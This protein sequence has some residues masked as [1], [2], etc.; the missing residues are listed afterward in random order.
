MRVRLLLTAGALALAGCTSLDTH[1]D[2]STL[3]DGLRARAGADLP[4]PSPSLSSE[5]GD[6]TLALLRAPIDDDAAVK[7][8]LLENHRVRAV[9]ERLGIARSDLVQAGLLRNPVFDADARFLFDGGTE[10]ELGLAQPFVDLFWLPLRT[11]LAEH[12]F[13]AAQALLTDELVHVVFAVRRAMAHARAAN[14]VADVARTGLEAATASH[15]L[16]A[17]LYA[18]GNLTDR[19]I[20]VERAGE[21]RARLDLAA[22]ELAAVEARE[23]LQ[24]LLGLWGAHTEWSLA[25]ELAADPLQ[26]VDLAHVEGRAIANSLPLAAHRAQLD[27]IAQRIGLR[28]WQRLLPDGALGLSAIREPG[29]EWGLGPRV[30][31]E[32]PLFDDGTTRRTRDEHLLRAGLHEQ[33]QLAVE[34]RS[35]ARVLR[36]R[37]SLL[38]ERVRFLH[39]VHLPQREQVVR[40]TLQHYNAMQIGV[41]DVLEQ[42]RRQLADQ[43]EY[44]LALRD[45]HL[46][47]LDLQELLAGSVPASAF[48]PL[49]AGDSRGDEEA[50]TA[51]GHR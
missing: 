28:S 38:A 27:A 25:G 49:A 30:S 19:A 4:A 31:L 18:A 43:R 48:Q 26:G 24:R 47:R 5:L 21:T 13:A 2:A 22:A 42:R 7:I 23:P 41:F 8:A 6:E 34:I 35:A 9:Y 37:A 10:L 39:D 1:D 11:R 44:V 29:G 46:A 50:A 36:E 51:G 3:H 33:I 32:L 17:A 45:A 15:E 16:A 12:E 14:R 20:A 40:T